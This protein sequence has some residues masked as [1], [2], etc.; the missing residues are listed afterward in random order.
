MHGSR[1]E[2][3]VIIYFFYFFRLRIGHRPLKYSLKINGSEDKDEAPLVNLYYNFDPEI[4]DDALV[5][6]FYR[7]GESV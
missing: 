7:E 6:G 3:R 4:E 2:E 5:T 1:N